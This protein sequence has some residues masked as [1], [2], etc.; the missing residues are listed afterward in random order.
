[1]Q[2]QVN[3]QLDALQERMAKYEE[4]IDETKVVSF[5]SEVSKSSAPATSDSLTLVRQ[6]LNRIDEG[7][8][9]TDVLTTL[10]KESAQ[11]VPR[12][13]LFVLKGGS[14]IGWFGQG[15]DQSPGF[16]NEAI[17]RISVPSNA[18][19]VFRAVI[20]S[21]E[22]FVGES[23]GH[24]DN[25]QLLSRLGNVLPSTIFAIPL[26]L[27]D[28]IAA[29]LYADSGD[30]QEG[31]GETDG[32]EVLVQYACKQLDLL[33]L[34]KG[35]APA[36]PAPSQPEPAAPQA[37]AAVAPTPAAVAPPP[38]APP[39]AEPPVTPLEPAVQEPEEEAGTVYF[40]AED[41]QPQPPAAAPSAP[42]P[43]APVGQ[44]FEDAKRFA[45]LLVSEIKLYN[46]AKVLQGRK[47]RD[48]YE[49]LKEDID[50]SRNLF[51]E[52]HSDA[53]VDLFNDELVRILAEG[54]PGALGQSF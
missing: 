54:D 2:E 26:I 25:V 14:C 36:E 47:N 20:S 44:E 5:A 30:A 42:P 53:P 22:G 39:V 12:V 11:L 9:L 32:V 17:R 4:Y 33:S 27:R 18:D 6:S 45:R 19:T 41:V 31:L 34:S 16:S 48:L 46:E 23:T 13:A 52:R 1:M 3:S 15:F 24:R 40:K 38:A 43:E 7:G 35:R 10:V 50:R 51:K 8:S 28:R 37:P 21:R 29:V 49:L